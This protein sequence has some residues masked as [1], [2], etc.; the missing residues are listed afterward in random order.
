[1]FSPV[2]V[3]SPLPVSLVESDRPV[4]VP[5]SLSGGTC[6]EVVDTGESHAGTNE[7]IPPDGTCPEAASAKEH[8]TCMA[9][10]IVDA[11]IAAPSSIQLIESIFRDSLRVAWV[12]LCSL[13]EGRS[14]EALLAE[15]ENILASFQALAEFSRQDLTCHGKKLKDIFYKARRIKKVQCKASSSKIHDKFVA[16]RASLDGLSSKLLHEGEAVGRVRA[17]LW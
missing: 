17:T 16:A 11:T 13:V 5:S 9:G 2:A 6:T 3:F 10:E 12:E 1:M 14:H 8:P 4:E 7:F 15:E